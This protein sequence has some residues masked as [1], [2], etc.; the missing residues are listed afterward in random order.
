MIQKNKEENINGMDMI[1]NIKKPSCLKVIKMTIFNI[2]K[3]SRYFVL[4]VIFG[5]YYLGSVSH[6][7][8]NIDVELYPAS[9]E[10]DNKDPPGLIQNCLA[11][12]D[13]I[14]S[15]YNVY[16]IY[17]NTQKEIQSVLGRSE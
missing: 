11:F 17:G 5:F 14:F 4:A 8:L 10:K 13:V 1:K 6:F 3:M 16:G 7:L 12:S 15:N 2:I 9:T